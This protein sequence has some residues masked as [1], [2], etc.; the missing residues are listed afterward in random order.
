MELFNM[1]I[2]SRRIRHCSRRWQSEAVGANF[3]Q[4]AVSGQRTQRRTSG[5]GRSTQTAVSRASSQRSR[6]RVGSHS[7]WQSRYELDFMEHT[8][9]VSHSVAHVLSMFDQQG[10]E[11]AQQRISEGVERD[12]DKNERMVGDSAGTVGRTRRGDCE[13][14]EHDLE[15][16]QHSQDAEHVVY[17]WTS[18]ETAIS[19][20]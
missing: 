10:A 15:A 8:P 20:T 16:G 17:P 4:G 14:V 18:S 19:T 5:I 7:T 2:E 9:N 12:P 11:R 1:K 3:T 13:E 6:T